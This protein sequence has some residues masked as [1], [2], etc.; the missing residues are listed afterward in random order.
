M[1]QRMAH[2]VAPRDKWESLWSG[3][4]VFLRSGK[5]S[6]DFSFEVLDLQGAYCFSS[7]L[8]H[9]Q[10][11]PKM[12]DT[13]WRLLL[14]LHDIGAVK[15]CPNIVITES[16]SVLWTI[17]EEN[18]SLAQEQRDGARENP[19]LDA[20]QLEVCWSLKTPLATVY[21]QALEA[22]RRLYR[23]NYMLHRHEYILAKSRQKN[24]ASRARRGHA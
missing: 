12:P 9:S 11:L 23:L 19:F 3:S 6:H 17:I 5:L 2:E 22:F 8:V 4:A 24:A 13:F 1:M 16:K 15:F 7:S 14:E 18:A 10:H 20:G 21:T